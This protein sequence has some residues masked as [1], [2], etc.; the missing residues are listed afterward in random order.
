[1]DAHCAARVDQRGKGVD[2]LL[3]AREVWAVVSNL[4]GGLVGR[5]RRCGRLL[6]YATLP[7]RLV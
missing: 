4:H 3:Q 6:F 5:S 2:E 7:H 1:M